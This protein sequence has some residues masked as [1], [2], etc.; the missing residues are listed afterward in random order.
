MVMSDKTTWRRIVEHYERPRLAS[1]VWQIVNSVLPY[2]ALWYLMTVTV[3][4]SYPLTLA[5][6]VLAA[7]FWVRIF[8][9]SHDCGHGSFFES[10][11][12]NNFWGGLTSVL[13]LIPYRYWRM[14]HARHHGSSG[15]LDRR[16]I[17]DIWTMTVEEYRSQPWWRRAAYRIYRNPF[18]MFGLGSAV[19]FAIFYRFT[20]GATSKPLRRSV[21]RTNV[22]LLVMAVAMIAWIGWAHFLM[23]FLP[24]LFLGSAIGAWLFYVQH[25][26]EGVYWERDEHWDYLKQAMEGSSYYRLPR[27]LQW[28]T[29]NIGFHHIHHLSHRIPNYNLP[30]CHA[31]NVLFQNVPQITL[32]TSLKSLK[33]RLWDEAKRKLV[34]FGALRRSS[35]DDLQSALG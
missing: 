2:L 29:G 19:A 14:E 4:I 25:Q 21:Y 12:A 28:F 22:A 11:R 20:D 8:I 18:I 35:G 23:I 30:R 5:L 34:G 15:N 10:S 9:I 6:V 13:T 7:G 32:L 33:F 26:F 1:S 16:G 17:G 3:G 31:E 27:V 24:L